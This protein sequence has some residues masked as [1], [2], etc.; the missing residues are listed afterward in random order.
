MRARLGFGASPSLTKNPC[1]I[2]SHGCD[3]PR[4]PGLVP[5]AGAGPIKTWWTHRA[6]ERVDASHLRVT[7]TRSHEHY[8][9][10]DPDPAD[11]P[12]PNSN[13]ELSRTPVPETLDSAELYDFALAFDYPHDYTTF[14]SAMVDNTPGAASTPGA[15][16]VSSPSAP[17]HSNSRNFIPEVPRLSSDPTKNAERWREEVLD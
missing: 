17:F 13:P 2:N 9:R 1:W 3:R 11:I 12:V 5:L 4:R 6:L 10:G 16:G 15:A 14:T 7:W 8:V